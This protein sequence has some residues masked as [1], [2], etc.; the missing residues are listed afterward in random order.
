M[1]YSSN[2]CSA[3][4]MR[5]RDSIIHP[6]GVV[7]RV[8]VRSNPPRILPFLVVGL[9]GLL[10]VSVDLFD[11]L[12]HTVGGPKWLHQLDVLTAVLLT[13]GIIGLGAY[14]SRHN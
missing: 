6:G 4:V 2:G 5:T 12:R 11:I 3:A 14:S 10:G 8:N 9:G 13:V 7:V 1:S